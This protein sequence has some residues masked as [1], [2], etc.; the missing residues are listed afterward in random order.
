M[1]GRV[2]GVKGVE[3]GGRVTACTCETLRERSIGTPLVCLIIGLGAQSR[4][5]VQV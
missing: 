4:L 3:G 5:A 2:E 1:K